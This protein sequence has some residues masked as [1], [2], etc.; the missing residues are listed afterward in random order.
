M[1]K[2]KYQVKLEIVQSEQNKNVTYQ[3]AWDAAE[4]ILSNVMLHV[5][6]RK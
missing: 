2:G 1:V 5:Y 4:K 3:Y 6:V